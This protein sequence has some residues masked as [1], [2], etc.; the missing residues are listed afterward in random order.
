MYLCNCLYVRI[1]IALLA[2]PH[3]LPLHDMTLLQRLLMASQSASGMDSSL[4]SS[5]QWRISRRAYIIIKEQE[6]IGENV[7]G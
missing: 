1:G 2:R 5:S 3:S 6:K 4:A 7:G